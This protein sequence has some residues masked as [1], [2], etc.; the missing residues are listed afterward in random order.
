M[1]NQKRGKHP[2]ASIS[3]VENLK[4]RENVDCIITAAGLSSRMG[5]WKMML[6][7]KEGTILDSSIENARQFCSRII[8]VVGYRG[9]ELYER[10]NTESDI[11]VVI[12]NN[13]ASGL[14]S[15]I[16]AAGPIVKT[17][18][19]FITHGDIPCLNREIFHQVWLKRG[20]YALLPCHQGTPGHPVLLPQSIMK[21]ACQD[22]VAV[23]SMR[24]FLLAGE[25]RYLNMPQPQTIMDIDTPEAYQRLLKI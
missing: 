21:R 13:Y 4:P 3:S 10:Y 15:S 19:C 18:Y 23:S 8:L 24:E 1:M 7:Y 11:T 25:Y 16:R 17:D 6:P 20:A 14:F 5:Q 22:D 12:N 2:C 9:D